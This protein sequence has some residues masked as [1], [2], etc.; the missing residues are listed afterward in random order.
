MGFT[1]RV[2]LIVAGA[3]GFLVTGAPQVVGQSSGDGFLFR[4][5]VGSVSVYGGMNRATAGSD[6]FDFTTEYLTLQRSDFDGATFGG[7]VS[8]RLRPRLDLVIGSSYTSSIASSEDRHYLFPDDRPIEQTTTFTRVPVMVGLKSYLSPPGHS[9]GRHAWVPAR[10]APYV[11]V[12]AGGMWHS[13]RQ[14]G[15]FVDFEDLGIFP[16]ESESR[17]WSPAAQA[18]GGLDV[19]ITTR[20]A[21]VGEAR[22]LYSRAELGTDFDGFEPLDLSGL[23]ATLGLSV[24]F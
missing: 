16:A 17:G 10:Y 21:L 22:Y 6:F 8:F 11:G 14:E 19:S 2:V 23:S 12:S 18:F 13:F 4:A 5:P 7:D 9:V 15:L 20:L 24:R 1:S 3:A